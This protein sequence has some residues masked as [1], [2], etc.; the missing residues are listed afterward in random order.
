MQT[1]QHFVRQKAEE[2]EKLEH[3]VK[4]IEGMQEKIFTKASD[5]MYGRNTSNYYR[6]MSDMFANTPKELKKIRNS[7]SEG[8]LRKLECT[9]QLM[10][11]YSGKIRDKQIENM[12]RSTDQT[13]IMDESNNST[14]SS[15]ADVSQLSSKNKTLKKKKL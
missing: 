7:T 8:C 11:N 9:R 4:E 6:N 3:Q 5:I 2:E 14:C 1:F 15:F 10:Q 12:A 13:E